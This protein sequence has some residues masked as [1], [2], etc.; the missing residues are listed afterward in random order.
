MAATASKVTWGANTVQTF[1]SSKPS[2]PTPSLFGAAVSSSPAP[3]PPGFSS[4]FSTQPVTSPAP[5]TSSLFSPSKSFPSAQNNSFSQ[6]LGAPQQAAVQAHMNATMHQEAS[7]LGAQLMQLHAA[8]APIGV[9]SS[10][11]NACHFMHIFYDPITQAQRLEKMSLPN[12]P[13]KPPQLSDEIW[14]RALTRNPNPE[15]YF[16]VLV[17]SAEGLHSRLVAQ[18]SKMKLLEGYLDKLDKSLA[19]RENFND[20]VA[21]SLLDYQRQNVAIRNK[22]LR[23]MQKFEI[24]RGKN[25]P[26]LEAEFEVRQKVEQLYRYLD[27]LE[28]QLGE[29]QNDGKEYA[30]QWH[31]IQKQRQRIGRSHEIDDHLRR[32]AM[33]ILN[34][35]NVG[36]DTLVNATEKG[37]R[38]LKIVKEGTNL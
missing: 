28:G 24:C 29:V 16:P 10:N 33:E 13:P 19:N 9:P 21:M 22:L 2:T 20:A 27:L 3:A 1:A 23:I 30:R 25:I 8:Y 17:T 5:T 37:E 38:D 31:S 26:L 11:E 14:N 6:G 4:T 18:Q 7:R 12:Y 36:I 32:G 34:Q 35:S 15:E